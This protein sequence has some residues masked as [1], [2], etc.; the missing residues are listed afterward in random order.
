[1]KKTIGKAYMLADWLSQALGSSN[2]WRENDEQLV[3]HGPRGPMGPKDPRTQGPRDQVG[4]EPR[5][6]WGIGIQGPGI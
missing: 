3:N 5:D 6:P 4:Q 1:M 2:D